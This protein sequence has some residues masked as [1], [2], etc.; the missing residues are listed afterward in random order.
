MGIGQDKPV[1]VRK[2]M[3]I[4]TPVFYS[5]I[6][7]LLAIALWVG[8]SAV[9]SM[10]Q[11]DPAD[12]AETTLG[13][14][15]PEQPVV[16]DRPVVATLIRT[17]DAVWAERHVEVRTGEAHAPAP[18]TGGAELRE[19]DRYTLTQGFAQLDTK[20]GAIVVLEAPC[21]IELLGENHVKLTRG[22]LV[23]ECPTNR[24]RGFTVF[25]PNSRIVDIGTKFEI[26]VTGDQRE[27]VTVYDGHV[28]L[29]VRDSD[30]SYRV[31]SRISENQHA[32]VLS[33]RTVR[34]SEVVELDLPNTGQHLRVGQS[35]PNWLVLARSD[36]PELGAW[37]AFVAAGE[38]LSEWDTGTKYTSQ[39]ICVDDDSY[40]FPAGES[41]T[42]QYS[43]DIPH[44][45]KMDTV[46]IDVRFIV[47][48]YLDVIRVNGKQVAIETP[49]R[50]SAVDAPPESWNYREFQT[51]QLK[52]GFQGGRNTIEWTIRNDA[53]RN[54]DQ[55]PFGLRVEYKGQAL[56][57]T[58]FESN[59]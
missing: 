21:E 50:Q 57:S 16:I 10:M 23:G 2:R 14:V 11:D 41:A 17:L 12:F 54:E 38:R 43:F 22:R 40:L 51:I 36:K 30:E 27:E 58:K 7:A 4:P 24:S 20:R 19:G 47:D 31:V 5:G 34:M 3:V 15:E 9:S 44:D 29:S 32:E 49:S 56:R 28:E 18:L 48:D 33:D 37:S 6:A 8:W 26:H 25:S 46:V 39:W 42:F 13:P 45:I 55:N 35:D 1:E 52:T 53:M 59:I